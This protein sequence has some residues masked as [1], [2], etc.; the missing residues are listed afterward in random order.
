MITLTGCSSQTVDTKE[1]KQIFID[2]TEQA[3]IVYEHYNGMDGNL[4]FVEMMGP[5]AAFF[6]YDNDGDLDVYIGQGGEL[7]IQSTTTTK[8]YHGTLYRNDL[9]DNILHF[10]DV[11][12]ESGLL[13]TEYSMGIAIGDINNDGFVDVYLTSF[14]AN[15]MFLNNTDGSFKEVTEYTNT[16]D[17]R[18][19]TSA[20]FFDMDG[21]NWLDLYVANYVDYTL[22][23]HKTCISQTGMPEYCG[24]NAYPSLK[25]RLFKNMGNG[26]FVNHTSASKMTL[27]GA[28]LGVVSGDFNLD[29]YQDIYVTNDMGH[30]FM[31]MNTKDKA[32]KNEGLIRG[33]AVNKHGKP[34]ASM[35][36]DAGDFDNDG[37]LD[38][39]MTHLLNETNTNYKNNGKGYFRDATSMIGLAEP[40]KG[41]TG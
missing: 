35:G 10:T 32:F 39:F 27:K 41:Y 12:K 18:W 11:T 31:W 29:G 2:V 30:N 13:S 3:G 33:N 16:E 40:S 25:D 23:G 24:P 15:H 19:S 37:D 4:Y 28:G 21:D 38:L 1:K 17:N 22:A 7:Q 36:V 14:G 20:A 8:K 9:K 26:K 34:E 6:D 5:A